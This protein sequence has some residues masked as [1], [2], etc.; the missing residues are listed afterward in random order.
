MICNFEQKKIKCHIEINVAGFASAHSCPWKVGLLS[1]QEER[2][3]SGAALIF[4]PSWKHHHTLNT[5]EQL[6][7]PALQSS[8]TN[9]ESLPPSI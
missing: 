1:N 7:P 4:H 5:P 9:C 6:S 8:S 2:R 3:P